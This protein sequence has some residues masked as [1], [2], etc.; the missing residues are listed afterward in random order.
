MPDNS[1]LL[2]LRGDL[3]GG[4]TAAIVALPLALAF[5]VASGAGPQAGLYGAIALGLVATL[6]GG[7]PTQI[8]GPTGPMTVVTASALA[9]FHGDL[10]L[11]MGVIVLAGFFQALLGLLRAG[12]LIRYIPYP[13][14]SGFMSGIGL[15]I[16]LLQIAPLLGAPGQSAPLKAVVALPATLAAV[17]P[18]SLLLG[19]GALLLLFAIPPRISRRLP[20]PL[21]ALIGGTVIAS[22][23]HLP[24]AT[25]GAIPSGLPQLMLPSFA[26]SQFPFLVTTALTLGALAAIDSLLTSLVADS[27][28]RSEH[29]P[30]RE[31][32]GQGMGNICAALCGGIPG[33]GATMR[34]VVNIKSGGNSRLSGVVHASVLLV[35]LLGLGDYAALVPMPILAAILVKVGIDIIDYRFL[36]ILRQAPRHDLAVMLTVLCLTVFV[37][38]IVAVGVGIVLASLLLT[39]R[40]VLQTTVDVRGVSVGKGGICIGKEAQELSDLQIRVVN[41]DGPFFFGSASQIVGQIGGLLG[42]KVVIFN[43]LHV[44]FIDLSAFF[45]LSE[46]ILRLK[47]RQIT[48]F[49]VAP[50]PICRKLRRLGMDETLRSER[51]FTDLES[52]LAAA[53]EA[54][55]KSAPTPRSIPGPPLTPAH[56]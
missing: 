7:T 9:L 17:E 35:I 46:M 26:T 10:A 5:G 4:L 38:L 39:R 13:V 52:A 6:L 34:T 30:N 43:C 36:R 15:I 53:E 20:S 55:E 44:P 31:L 14:I 19:G 54:L 40:L 37:D 47:S 42:T 21:L 22:L 2:R 8:S 18:A 29:N 56:R 16:I 41:I 1:P 25:I 49:I 51:L 48:P 33:A 28:T 27:L 50:D 32:I 3:F 12:T 24:V 23:F 11:L 45:A